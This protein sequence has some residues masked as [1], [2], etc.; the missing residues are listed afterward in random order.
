M[1][2]ALYTSSVEEKL[3]ISSH[4]QAYFPWWFKG[5]HHHEEEIDAVM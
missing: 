3:R 5:I 4:T 1:W 2:E